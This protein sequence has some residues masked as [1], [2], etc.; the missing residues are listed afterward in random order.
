MRIQ[1]TYVFAATLA[2][3]ALVLAACSN[4]ISTGKGLC[5]NIGDAAA[6]A[7]AT[8]HQLPLARRSPEGAL[9]GRHHF[10]P[11]TSLIFAAELPCIC[12]RRFRS[13]AETPSS[14]VQY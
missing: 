1:R 10:L 2:S 14:L 6:V 4:Q 3:F 13:V 7:A 9:P 11:T 12:T 8:Q 5:R